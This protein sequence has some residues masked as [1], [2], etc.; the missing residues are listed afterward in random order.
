MQRI[1]VPILCVFILLAST[2]TKAEETHC[3]GEPFEVRI[4]NYVELFVCSNGRER[5]IDRFFEPPYRI[6]AFEVKRPSASTLVVVNLPRTLSSDTKSGTVLVYDANSGEQL[7]KGYS[8]FPASAADMNSDGIIEIVLFED[9]LAFNTL[10]LSD[11][12]WPTIIELGDPITIG[13]IEDY[14]SLRERLLQSAIEAK[15]MLKEVCIL[16]GV[17]N[18]L[19]G[20]G[21]DI[22]AVDLFIDI[23]SIPHP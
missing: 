4:D 2:A 1:P 13:T 7:L 12:G 19:C 21:Q 15:K 20:A 6:V 3:P 8:K 18:P 9:F 23:L 17:Y 5:M 11:V 14:D 16:D 10:V 22:T